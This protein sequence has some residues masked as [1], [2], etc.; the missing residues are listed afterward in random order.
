M[1]DRFVNPPPGCPDGLAVAIKE[2]WGVLQLPAEG[3]PAEVAQP[4]LAEIAEH[5][6]E[7]VRRGYDVVTVGEAL[8][9][10]P[11]LGRLGAELNDGVVPT[12]EAA[13]CSFLSN[14]PPPPAAFLLT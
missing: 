4:I 12:D 5:V 6:E 7:F 8:A 2:G 11:A 1:A 10:A 3:Y 14:R 9:L 13:L